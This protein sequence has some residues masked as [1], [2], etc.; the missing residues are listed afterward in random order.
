MD[1]DTARIVDV[2]LAAVCLYVACVIVAR[3]LR[4]AEPLVAA[5]VR[6]AKEAS[7]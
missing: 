2:V 5:A 7:S 3:A 1:H 6:L 4:Q